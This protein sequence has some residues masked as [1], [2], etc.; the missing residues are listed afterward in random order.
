MP[1]SSSAVQSPFFGLNQLKQ[2]VYHTLQSV[3]VSIS[4]SGSAQ[5][6]MFV[7]I[8]A[9]ILVLMSLLQCRD[10]W[11]WFHQAK[12]I[13]AQKKA[14]PKLQWLRQPASIWARET[15]GASIT[16]VNNLLDCVGIVAI[17]FITTEGLKEHMGTGL[18]HAILGHIVIQG[19]AAVFSGYETPMCSPCYEILPYMKIVLMKAAA[20]CKGN[21]QCEASTALTAGVVMNLMSGIL[22]FAAG[23]FQLSLLLRFLPD[24]LKTGVLAGIG[25]ICVALGIELCCDENFFDMENPVNLFTDMS[26]FIL[27]IPGVLLGLGLYLFETFVVDSAYTIPIFFVCGVGTFQMIMQ[28]SGL[29]TEAARTDGWLYTPVDSTPFY[30]LWSGLFS[31]QVAWSA[32]TESLPIFCMG[33]LTGPF[34][35]NVGD[36]AMTESEFGPDIGKSKIDYEVK[37]QGWAHIASGLS[38]GFVSDFGNDDTQLH[39]V[40]GGKTRLSAILNVILLSVFFFASCPSFPIVPAII[41][42]IPKCL[43]GA[44]MILAAVEMLIEALVESYHSLPKLEYTVIWGV[45]IATIIFQGAIEKALLIGLIMSF[46]VFVFQ[47]S[48]VST[49]IFEETHSNTLWPTQSD[50][51]LWKERH[52]MIIAQVSGYVFFANAKATVDKIIKKVKKEDLKVLILDFSTTKEVDD[53]A[54]HELDRLLTKCA[55]KNVRVIFAGLSTEQMVLLLQEEVIEYPERFK[56]IILATGTQNL[57]KNEVF[58]LL[59][60]KELKELDK[61]FEDPQMPEKVWENIM[62][63]NECMVSRFELGYVL[64]QICPEEEMEDSASERSG[65]CTEDGDEPDCDVRIASTLDR[66]VQLAEKALIDG[67]DKPPKTVISKGNLEEKVEA[68]IKAMSC[69]DEVKDMLLQLNRESQRKTAGGPVFHECKDGE[70]I[71][72]KKSIWMIIDGTVELYVTFHADQTVEDRRYRRRIFCAQKSLT[73]LEPITQMPINGNMESPSYEVKGSTIMLEIPMG[74]LDSLHNLDSEKA[75]CFH[76]FARKQSAETYS[77]LIH[78]LGQM[79]VR[80]QLQILAKEIEQESVPEN[81]E[82]KK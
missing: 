1:I 53:T 20:A 22:M 56:D 72:A 51:V 71:E 77:Q 3:S 23:R 33:I 60:A 19:L 8:I 5:G 61:K 6:W 43:N 62:S 58:E 28:F 29:T 73:T 39:R 13:N 37:V 45:T 49:L 4:T 80:K 15:M 41:S 31:G 54:S 78:I 66:A 74:W 17:L 30:Q 40:G 67:N 36:L 35:N 76:R 14:R 50:E 18:K 75:A 9:G 52:N 82:P 42:V 34:L 38:G 16:T 64:Q 44:S 81:H 21:S 57:T 70:V 7:S 46:C 32:I 65:A 11:N 47:S 12:K 24:S 26:L 27:W 69:A 48:A 63:D 79:S 59:Q 68:I 2:R 25:I 55:E 10:A